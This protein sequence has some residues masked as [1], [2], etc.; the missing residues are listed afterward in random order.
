M[1]NPIALE[2]TSY[3]HPL[4][5]GVVGL[6]MSSRDLTSTSKELYIKWTF[7][8]YSRESIVSYVVMTVAH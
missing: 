3:R 6:F 1:F 5:K 7:A 2:L 8:R 4:S